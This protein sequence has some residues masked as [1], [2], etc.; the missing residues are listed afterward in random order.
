M[1]AWLGGGLYIG[2]GFA[3]P[4]PPAPEPYD[5]TYECDPAPAP[6]QPYQ[7]PVSYQPAPVMV[8]AAAHAPVLPRFGIGAF[9]GSTNIDGLGSGDDVGL[10]ARY[11]LTHKL[12]L[13]GEMAKSQLRDM[14]RT[15]RRMGLGLLYDFN[16]HAKLSLH[17]LG[18]LGMVAADAS[19]NNSMMSE[20]GYGEVGAG[21]TYRITP[22]FQL[23]A[24]LRAGSLSGDDSATIQPTDGVARSIVA[25]DNMN[26]SAY[27]RARLSA[28][29]FF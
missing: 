5:A 8:S 22:H 17:L 4:P 16:P 13:E 12:Y 11:R 27:T 28:L 3:Q 18:A 23:A 10:T 21:L 15:E 14:D 29:F 20:Q 2:G 26:S 6:V 1:G 24:D 25:P 9:A 19:S 7:P